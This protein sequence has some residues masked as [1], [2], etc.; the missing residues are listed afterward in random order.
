[1]DTIESIEKRRSV[2]HYQPDH[3]MT[4]DELE[5]LIGLAALAPT[6]FNMQNWRFVVI[7]DKEK[8]QALREAAWNQAQVT[9]ASAVIVICADL[10]AHANS[11]ERYWANAPKEVSDMLVPMITGFYEGKEQ[12]QRDE[13]NRSAGIAGQ[14]IMLAAKAMGYDTCPMVGFDPVKVAEI[15]N[16]PKDHYLSF[17]ITVGKALKE[18]QPRGG[19]LALD[20]IMIRDSF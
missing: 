15:I 4:K 18:A 19:Q 14:T 2:K 7:T 20:E 17:M 8:R 16:L 1:M 9:E 6:S 3:E 13:A 12:L 10:Q 11:P 5:K